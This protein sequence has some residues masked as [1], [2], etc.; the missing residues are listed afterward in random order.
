M[1]VVATYLCGCEIWSRKRTIQRSFS[2]VSAEFLRCLFHL[3]VVRSLGPHHVSNITYVTRKHIQGVSKR[4][5]RW[6]PNAPVWRVLWKLLNL[7]VYKLPIVEHLEWFWMVSYSGN[8]RPLRWKLRFFFRNVSSHSTT[9]RYIPE[10]GNIS[11]YRCESLKSD[12]T[13]L[14]SL[15]SLLKKFRKIWF[16]KINYKGVRT[17]IEISAIIKRFLS[18]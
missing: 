6:Q 16:Q 3:N 12:K 13:R 4:A 1:F 7:K 8:Y 11:N 2:R 17:G 5:L 14:T 10:D 15:L 9:G 18:K